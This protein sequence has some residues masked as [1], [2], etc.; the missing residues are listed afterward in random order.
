V[1]ERRERG[2]MS[3]VMVGILVLGIALLLGAA[4]VGAALLALGRAETAA[5]AAALA[6]ADALALGGNSARAEADAADSAAANGAR[7]VS[8]QC[9]GRF[10]TVTVVVDVPVLGRVARV[11]ARAE[12]RGVAIPPP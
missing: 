7:L 12:V 10:A 6:A 1:S 5:D 9:S 2:A 8:C 3:I 4:R 11:N